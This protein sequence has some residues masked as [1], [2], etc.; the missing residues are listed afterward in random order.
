MFWTKLA[1]YTADLIAL[2]GAVALAI[3]FTLLIGVPVLG[4]F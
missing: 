3:P 4:S 2:I 1:T